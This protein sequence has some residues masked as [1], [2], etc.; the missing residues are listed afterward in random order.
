MSEEPLACDREESASALL[1]V[2]AVMGSFGRMLICLDRE[3]RVVHTSTLLGEI[4]GMDAARA[5][6]GHPVA[7][8][9]GVELFAA[10]GA[11]RHA[12]ELGE[13]REGW[14]ASM[15]LADGTTRLVSC[16]AAPLEHDSQGIC[17]PNVAYVIIVRPAEED[18]ST[19]TASPVGFSGMIARSSA[20]T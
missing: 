11:L 12:L 8:L 15:A 18:P 6:I 2:S 13:R 5:L 3:F 7:E 4:L 20:M 19:G 16:S 1:A 14:R 10:D 17:D 9:L